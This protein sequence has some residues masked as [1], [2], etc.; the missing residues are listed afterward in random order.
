[1][2]VPS[3]KA[4]IAR[5]AEFLEDP[6][7]DERS[8]EDVAGIIV[9]G[10]YDMWERGVTSPPLTLKV[11]Q[12]FKSP[13]SSKTYHVGHI[14]DM[15]W[16]KD[17]GVV[18]TAW[19]I[20]SASEYGSLMPVDRPYWRIVKP[21]NAKVGGPGTNDDGWKVGDIVSLSQRKQAF[22]LIAVGLKTVLMHEVKSPTMWFSEGNT[23]LKRYYRKEN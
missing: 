22:K 10:M 20:D 19:V 3:E 16:N 4:Q 5:V 6:D 14:G 2:A 15:F 8:V 11:G 21:S 7:N 13:M 12:A 18:S 17:K 1:M 23:N 9:R